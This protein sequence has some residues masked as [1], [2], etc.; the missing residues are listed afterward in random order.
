MSSIY[1]DKADQETLEEMEYLL[2]KRA[3]YGWTQVDADRYNYL[4]STL[5][6]SR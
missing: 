2:K 5:K 1:K 6:G 4:E 3:E